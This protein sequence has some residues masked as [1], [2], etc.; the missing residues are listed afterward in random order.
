MSTIANRKVTMGLLEK[1]NLQAK[2]R[3]GQNFIVDPSVVVAIAEKSQIEADSTI[4]EI[5]PGLGALTQ[6]LAKRA[7]QVIAVEVDPDMVEVLEHELSM[8]NVKVVHQD[9]LDMDLS[10]LKDEKLMVVANVPYYITTPILFKLIE[11]KLPLVSITLMIQKELADRLSAKVNTKEYNA[12]SLM[13]AYLYQIKPILQIPKQ[14]FHP[15]PKVDST[16]IQL[17]PTK[18]KEV[19]NEAAFF[20]F[21]KTSFQMKRKTL[22][23]N[24]KTIIEREEIEAV[25]TE[26][27]IATDIRAE[28]VSLEQFIK[29]YRSLYE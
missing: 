26:L 21:L 10:V 17:L 7:K 18:Q 2:K 8:D 12:L 24:L 9:F 14:C 15:K 5:G 1:Y 23:N 25:L 22:V 4:L 16:V 19:E 28:G 13:I 6:Q 11:S 29:I 3:L 20:E 27:K